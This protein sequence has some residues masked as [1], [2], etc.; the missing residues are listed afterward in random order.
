MTVRY[1]SRRPDDLGLRERL[2]T[3]AHERRRFGY[4]RP[5]VLLRREATG[6][7]KRV[8]RLYG[9]E[10]LLVRRRRGRKRALGTR[11]PI[12]LPQLANERWSLDFLSDHSQAQ[13]A[14]PWPAF[15]LPRSAELYC[16]G[17]PERDWSVTPAVD[18]DL[19]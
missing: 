16:L 7:H 10:R 5:H 3:L 6:N 9:E 12:T 11:A 19:R 18:N 4:R 1:R 13:H 2:R 15:A 8:Y 17:P 14:Q